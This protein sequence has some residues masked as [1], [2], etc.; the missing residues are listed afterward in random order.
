MSINCVCAHSYECVL[1]VAFLEVIICY[2]FVS[3]WDHLTELQENL[4]S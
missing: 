4:E 3:K 1:K 2:F